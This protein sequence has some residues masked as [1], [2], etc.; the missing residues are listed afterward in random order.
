MMPNL[1]RTGFCIGKKN[2]V[3]MASC[4]E[5]R[6]EA[7]LHATPSIA[8]LELT[9]TYTQKLW[10]S[11]FLLVKRPALVGGHSPRL[12][13]HGVMPSIFHTSL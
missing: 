5:D 6:A 12:R 7:F 11:P 13:T 1:F 3:P 8:A 10:R 2:L 9:R 4:L